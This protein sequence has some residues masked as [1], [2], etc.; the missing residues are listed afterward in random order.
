MDRD[1]I[2]CVVAFVRCFRHAHCRFQLTRQPD[3]DFKIH[4]NQPATSAARSELYLG[5]WKSPCGMTSR[6]FRVFRPW[7]WSVDNDRSFPAPRVAGVSLSAIIVEV[8]L[9]LVCES[10]ACRRGF[11]HSEI[12]RRLGASMYREEHAR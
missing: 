9:I 11:R 6:A 2:R 10:A 5:K 3:F 4:A 12:L 7:W 1:H 8:I